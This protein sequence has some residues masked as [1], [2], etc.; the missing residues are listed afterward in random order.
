MIAPRYDWQFSKITDTG[1]VK[2]I[3]N[4]FGAS[5]L[6]A[7]ILVERGQ[8]SVEQVQKFLHPELED[9]HDPF[10]MHDMDK[11][12]ERIM[13][14]IDE[15]ERIVVYGDYDV[16][17]ITSTAIMTLALEIMGA[18]VTYF[19]PNRFKDGYGPNLAE[20]QRLAEDGMQLLVT[21]DNG[22]SGN[23]E[24]EWLMKA[25]IDVIITDHHEMPATLP[26]AY[27]VVHPRHPEGNYPFGGLSGA[28]VAFK[29]ASALLEAPA[30]EMLDL[31]ALGTI[32]DV[33]ELVD[34]NRTLVTLGLE[35]LRQEPRMGLQA[36]L[37]LAGVNPSKVDAGTV[38][39][40]IGPR[41][42][43]LGRMKDATPGVRFLLSDDSVEVSEL[44]KEIDELN[45]KRKALVDDITDA[46]LA[47]A[48]GDLQ[49]DPVLVIAGENWHEGVLG[50]VASK[51][52]EET[53]KPTIILNQ[54]D[55]VLKGSA[56]SFAAFDLFEAM[57]GHRELYTNFGGHALAAGMTIP[58]E[59]LQAV[60]DM[61]RAEATKQNLQADVK[62]PLRITAQVS[63]SA[64]N[65]Q[66]YSQIKMLA[67]FGN[68][69]P[70][71]LF[72]VDLQGTE[73]VKTMSDGKH[74]RLTGIT[75]D[76][77]LPII[78]WNRG[79][80]AGQL[81]GHFKELTFVGTMSANE[82]RGTTTYQMMTKDLKA[83]GSALVDLRTT[84]LTPQTFAEAATYIFFNKNMY[85]QSDRLIKAPNQAMWWEDAFNTTGLG[86]MALVDLPKDLDELHQV[87]A[88]VPA[89]G[90]API[91]YT[92]HPAYLQ[93]VPTRSEFAVFYKFTKSHKDVAIKAQFKQI[94]AYLKLD[95]LMLSLVLK[96]FLD[97]KFV[98][99]ENGFLN[100]VEKPE[101]VELEKMPSFLNFLKKREIEQKLIYST[102]AE[103]ETLL[104]ELAKDDQA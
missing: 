22:V 36:L 47:Q 77:K 72:A 74:L 54:A 58:F 35:N 92:S 4:A 15:Q 75:Q 29:V 86:L 100:A 57:D 95:P 8:T 99:I 23:A 51:I 76:Q 71:P 9:L 48:T 65:E 21:V 68:G 37:D 87:L 43:S 96:V 98:T 49:N 7:Q 70:E 83:V 53:G 20:Y 91:F 97:A 25:G 41:L 50:I 55:G 94:A 63:G 19:V 67:P 3:Q 12:V 66:I 39:F 33:M 30:D 81:A 32:A 38:G 82:Y 42:N 28:G 18:D 78:A 5:E 11:A 40:Q 101:A 89:T 16:D 26:E 79:P 60:R 80:I 73:N 45:T 61:L 27:A 93:K 64:F 10:L 85:E 62:P 88:F 17:G 1:A 52:V 90:W 69:N 44:A 34:E 103:L 2:E 56:R 24:V 84:K 104:N 102:T 6:V 14:A 13:Q 46:A 59:N 31:T